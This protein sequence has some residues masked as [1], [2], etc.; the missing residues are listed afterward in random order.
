MK[1]ITDATSVSAYQILA[2][3]L[4]VPC[5]EYRPQMQEAARMASE[6]AVV[7]EGTSGIFLFV[8]LLSITLDNALA[9]C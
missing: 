7:L 1:P 6:M 9:H 8:C 3:W 2:K 4:P 5:S